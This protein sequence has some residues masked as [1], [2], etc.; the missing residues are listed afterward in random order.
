MSINAKIRGPFYYFR[1]IGYKDISLWLLAT[2]F[3]INSF[4]LLPILRSLQLVWYRLSSFV[5]FALALLPNGR[6]YCHM[7]SL[8][9][10]I[11]FFNKFSRRKKEISLIFVQTFFVTLCNE[12]CYSH[13]SGKS[14]VESFLL[15]MSHNRLVPFKLLP[16]IS[17]LS[18]YKTFSNDISIA[19]TW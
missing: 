17:H 16:F 6:L 1:L 14:Q 10:T 3:R 2:I 7:H 4:P 15:F 11:Y 13:L 18:D 8:F 9:R 19:M 12:N 5:F